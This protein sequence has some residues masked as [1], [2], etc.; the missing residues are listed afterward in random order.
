MLQTGGFWQVEI[1]YWL[2]DEML[3]GAVHGPADNWQGGVMLKKGTVVLVS[4]LGD[5][6]QKDMGKCAGHKLVPNGCARHL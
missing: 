6:P 5:D 4:G 2:A 1:D 3:D